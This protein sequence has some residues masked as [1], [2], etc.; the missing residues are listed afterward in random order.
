[1]LLGDG[2]ACCI[3]TYF[4]KHLHVDRVMSSIAADQHANTNIFLIK[5]YNRTGKKVG[6]P[7]VLSLIF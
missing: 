2:T 1:M 3:S 4:H 5:I 6:L 7:L